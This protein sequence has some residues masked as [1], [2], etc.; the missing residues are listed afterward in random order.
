MKYFPGYIFTLIISF[1]GIS[2]STVAQTNQL[3]NLFWTII[4]FFLIIFILGLLTFFRNA[5]NKAS[6]WSKGFTILC[7]ILYSALI[8]Y[9]N[10]V[11]WAIFVLVFIVEYFLISRIGEFEIKDNDTP[12]SFDNGIR[13]RS[14]GKYPGNH[15]FLYTSGSLRFFIRC[16]KAIINPTR[17]T[18]LLSQSK[19][20]SG[21]IVVFMITKSGFTCTISS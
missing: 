12:L 19:L 10:I 14:V 9:Y 17:R 21:K 5:Y 13:F 20:I 1:L 7:L 8:L 16:A 18:M 3:H 2:I 15:F 11:I 6:N 4:Y